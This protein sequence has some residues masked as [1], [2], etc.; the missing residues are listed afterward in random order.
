MLK[1]CNMIPHICADRG[2][3]DKYYYFVT[4][5][6]S[7]GQSVLNGEAIRIVN[8]QV[9]S[10][11][12]GGETNGEGENLSRIE[13]QHINNISDNTHFFAWVGWTFITASDYGS[14]N[15]N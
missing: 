3:C 10:R 15:I 2:N 11:A 1:C 8:K 14:D 6:Q 9:A 4:L 7:V 12:G 13:L 5:S